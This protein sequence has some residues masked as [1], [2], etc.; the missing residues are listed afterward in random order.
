M[1]IHHSPSKTKKSRYHHVDG[2]DNEATS[3]IGHS[4]T[5]EGP[6]IVNAKLEITTASP[7]SRE[8]MIAVVAYQHAEARGFT[9]G[10]DLDDWLSAEAEVNARLDGEGRAY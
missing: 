10:H 9:P 7:A 4:D 6:A 2:H 1:S 8:Q 5:T 3:P